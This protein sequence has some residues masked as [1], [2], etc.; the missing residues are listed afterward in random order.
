[1]QKPLNLADIRIEY[2]FE[3]LNEESVMPDPIEQI[4]LW[5]EEAIK[6]EVNEPNAMV[7]STVKNNNIPA[8]R[9]VLLKGLTKEGLIFFT[10]YNS[11]KGVQIN[12][13]PAAAVVFFWP[14]LQRQVRVE[15]LLEKIPGSDSDTYFKS[16]PIDSQ[17]GAIISPQS[18]K[19]Q[20]RL[21]L[22]E[23]YKKLKELFLTEP[24][25]NRPEHWG[26]Y[27]LKP[28]LF[29]FWQGRPNRLHDRIVFEKNDLNSWLISRLAP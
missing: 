26:G 27:I 16:R 4:A 15:G 9:V 1:M 29:E 28:A 7:L 17:I 20:S 24:I 6:S 12:N 18:K 11:N 14:E 25:L 10:N 5:L 3:M 13:N 22:E 23:S 2:T 8:A 21:E 19:I